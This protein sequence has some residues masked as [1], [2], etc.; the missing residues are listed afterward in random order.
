MGLWARR[1]C[2]GFG[3]RQISGLDTVDSQQRAPGPFV[4]I[5][6]LYCDMNTL[7]SKE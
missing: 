5:C 7:R 4:D 6:Q 1:I 2:A 3:E